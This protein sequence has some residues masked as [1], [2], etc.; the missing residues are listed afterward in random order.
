VKRLLVAALTIGA[1]A[2]VTGAITQMAAPP[3]QVYA[4]VIAAALVLGGVGYAFGLAA[5][6][7]PRPPGPGP[8]TDQP[9]CEHSPTAV[10]ALQDGA[11][12]HKA[13]HPGLTHIRITVQGSEGGAAS[14]GTPGQPGGVV[15]R[16]MLAE[17]IPECVH[18]RVGAGG[19][20]GGLPGSVLVSVYNS[21]C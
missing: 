12:F 2:A 19:R 21:G 7:A 15:Y 14:D 13:E 17:D 8:V 1:G 11:V 6:R 10:F 18:I 16:T 3:G 4:A 20:P 9:A 5:G